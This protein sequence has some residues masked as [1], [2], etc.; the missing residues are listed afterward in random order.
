[1]AAAFLSFL[2]ECQ[3]NV[4][5][6]HA[7]GHPHPAAQSPPGHLWRGTR[8]GSLLGAAGE[9]SNE[10]LFP[11]MGEVNYCDQKYPEGKTLHQILPINP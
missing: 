2:R 10:R 8:P 1:M 4:W 6:G 11:G 9:C 3:V 7:T 5:M